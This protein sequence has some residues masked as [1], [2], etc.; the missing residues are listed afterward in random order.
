[1]NIISPSNYKGSVNANPDY[2]NILENNQ[3]ELNFGDAEQ[4]YNFTPLTSRKNS[5]AFTGIPRVTFKSQIR[6]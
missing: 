6:T 2:L 3:D 5:I 1:M 4:N